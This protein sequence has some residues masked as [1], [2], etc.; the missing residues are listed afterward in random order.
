MWFAKKEID[1][2]TNHPIYQV[3]QTRVNF[4]TNGE[5]WKEKKLS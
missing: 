2:L 4:W 3:Q 5:I 1:V